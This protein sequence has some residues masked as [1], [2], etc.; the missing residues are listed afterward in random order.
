MPG[1]SP[2][3]HPQ[4]GSVLVER[5]RSPIPSEKVIDYGKLKEDKDEALTALMKERKAAY[6]IEESIDMIVK[7]DESIR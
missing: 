5:P 7:S 1:Q 4:D 2:M 3:K 6:G